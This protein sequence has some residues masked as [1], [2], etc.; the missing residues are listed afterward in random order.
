M[1]GWRGM[2]WAVAV[3][4]V[5]ALTAAG[6]GCGEDDAG[7]A[8]AGL[9]ADDPL[10]EFAPLL[11]LEADEPWRPMTAR[12]FIERSEFGISSVG[13]CP[14]RR[15]A[16]GHALPEER[17]DITSWIYP[18]GLGGWIRTAYFRNPLDA[19]CELDL[20]YRFS[21]DDLTRPY[22]PGL[23]VEGARPG[24]GF[25]IDL[26][27]DSRAG[28]LGQPG[29]KAEAY[30]ERTDE[31][32]AGVRLT[33]WTLYGMH[34]IPGQAGA[35]EGDWERVDVLLRDLGSD[36]Y[37]PLSVQV[38]A[39]G[40]GE[41]TTPGIGGQPVRDVAWTDVAREGTT[42]P[43]VRA[44]RATHDAVVERRGARCVACVGWETWR[45][46]E[47][48]RKEPWYGFGGAWGEV[49]ANAATTGP[50]GPRPVS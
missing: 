13:R 23:R 8:D 37:Q 5:L 20:T 48:A 38:P 27:D 45:T 14:D 30:G 33:Y 44:M 39:R 2:P 6:A 29:A 42:H 15:I 50:L 34:G 32:D 11:E 46:L 22:D 35:R 3:L 10:R 7:D 40:G 43:V 4:L 19:A 28:P 9:H 25:Y 18:E 47:P 41:G 36:R 31:G 26:L 1:E 12:W 17:T 21:A 49:G 24:E 16:V